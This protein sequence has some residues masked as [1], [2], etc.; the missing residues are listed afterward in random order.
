MYPFV[1]EVA[2]RS[3]LLLPNPYPWRPTATLQF[4]SLGLI[5]S[6]C[7]VLRKLK[8]ATH[9]GLRV[10]IKNREQAI[11][12]IHISLPKLEV[13]QMKF[14]S[15]YLIRFKQM[16]CKLSITV[17]IL[18]ATYGLSFFYEYIFVTS[19]PSEDF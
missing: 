4:F 8:H 6:V 10:C 14:L 5:I 19:F 9:V 11:P 3:P 13:R 18:I 1:G 17:F 7:F 16:S 12:L 2:P 15:L